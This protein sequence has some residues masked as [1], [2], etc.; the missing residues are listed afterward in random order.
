MWRKSIA[1]A[2]FVASVAGI[3]PAVAEPL[4]AEEARRFVVGKLFSFNCFEGT[5][6]SGRIHS[7]GSVAG[8]IQFQ[9]S[10]PVRYVTL[11]ANTLQVKGENVCGSVRGLPFEP[12]FNL[13][14]TSTQSFRGSI[15]GF[16]FAYCDFTRHSPR[17]IMTQAAGAPM[18]L[19]SAAVT[20][21][22]N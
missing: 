22:T 6:G 21:S 13:D 1:L 11:P 20:G 5:K 12:C 9:G 19:Q 3:Y 4:N 17:R 15:S 2:G 14:K 16:G 8:T 7:D 18:R 10:G